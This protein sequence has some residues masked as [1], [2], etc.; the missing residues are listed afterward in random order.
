MRSVEG[1]IELPSNVCGMGAVMATNEQGNVDGQSEPWSRVPESLRYLRPWSL[2]FG[3]RGLTAYFGRQP[4]LSKIASVDELAELKL[5]Y[6][7]IARRGDAERI[8]AWCLSIRPGDAAN[9]VKEQIRGL[10][11]L[12]ERLGDR[13]LTP[14]SDG[15]VRFVVPA[16]PPFDWS[17]LPEH[18]QLWK[19]WLQR[20]EHL[21]T[22]DDVFQYAQNASG[23]QLRELTSLSDL[24]RRDGH[25][26]R[27]WCEA[28]DTAGKPA[29][30]EAF[31]AE[32]LFLLEYFASSRIE[33]AT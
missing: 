12:F 27:G 24:L 17:V 10:L 11:L 5:A 30:R 32:W 18:L 2:K 16:P 29:A 33:N 23:D 31:Q 9:D 22:E 21:T 19:S 8:N 25:L 4:P 6:E 1:R 20:F 26:L 7:S 3:L 28:N 15:R 13:G 14:F